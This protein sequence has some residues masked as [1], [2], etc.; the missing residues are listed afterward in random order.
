MGV[1]LKSNFFLWSPDSLPHARG[2]VSIF[3]YKSRSTITSSPRTWG[4]FRSGTC[5]WV[6][7]LCLPHARGGVSETNGLLIRGKG[8]SPRT[9]GCFLWIAR[10][11]QR[12]EVFPTHVGVFLPEAAGV[13]SRR[14]LP[15]AR[16]GVSYE[17]LSDG[18]LTVSSPRTWGCFYPSRRGK[19]R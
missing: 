8:S 11:R 1:F 19:G 16:G 4:C 2:G 3:T 9:W 10:P 15:H 13:A 18:T 12:A 17:L 5:Q 6:S 14:G 7:Q